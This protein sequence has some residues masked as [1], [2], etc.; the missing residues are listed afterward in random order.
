MSIETILSI[1]TCTHTH[2]RTHAHTHRGTHTRKYS[3]HT[4]LKYPQ[5]KMGSKCLG[6][7]EWMKTSAQ[8]KKHGRSTIFGKKK[9]FRL[10]LNESRE[11]FCRRGRGRSFH[12]DGP[13]TEKAW[14]LTVESLVQGG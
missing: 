11:G 4:K 7:L 2:A 13:K 5:L 10:D 9:V 12:V 6:D 8:N 14:E 3:D 1:H